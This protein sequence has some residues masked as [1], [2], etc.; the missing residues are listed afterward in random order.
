MVK[1][2]LLIP[3]CT[4]CPS[5]PPHWV[6]KSHLAHSCNVKLASSA[7]VSLSQEASGKP[8]LSRALATG[9]GEGGMDEE[10]GWFPGK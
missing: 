1:R 8:R 6:L 7:V 2:Q 3:A 4:V 5:E 10:W 9:T